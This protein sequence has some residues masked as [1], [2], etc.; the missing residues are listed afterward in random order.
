MDVQS[1]PAGVNYN[2][3]VPVVPVFPADQV[4]VFSNADEL[5]L[6]RH[7]VART[8]WNGY[9]S[10]IIMPVARARL[11]FPDAM[12]F[13]QTEFEKRGRSN[14]TLTLKQGD[15][16]GHFTEQF[17]AAGAVV[18]LLLQSVGDIIRV[19]PAWPKE[20]D[21]KFTSLRAQGG[22]LVS[23]EQSRGKVTKLEITSTVGGKLRLLHPWTG[24]LVEHQTKPGQQLEIKP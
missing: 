18:E 15:R 8:K 17:A 6:F 16:C 5:A 22:F 7:A 2:I 4:T 21:A 10:S 20:K 24:T 23:A 19:F 9:N 1:A 12:Q 3:A 11:S 14:G 13:M